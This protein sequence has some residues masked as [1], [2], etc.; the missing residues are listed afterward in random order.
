[1]KYLFHSHPSE[2]KFPSWDQHF[3]LCSRTRTFL[4]VQVFHSD[5]QILE[6]MAMWGPQSFSSANLFLRIWAPQ[7][8]FC[9]YPQVI[10]PVHSCHPYSTSAPRF[11]S[12]EHNS[13]VF[14]KH[15]QKQAL[16]LGRLALAQCAAALS[17]ALWEHGGVRTIALQLPN[18]KISSIAEHQNSIK[19]VR[20]LFVLMCCYD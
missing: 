13:Q 3:P 6:C 16:Y 19:R 20:T 12:T 17:L 14:S 18:V 9:L 11:S 7:S 4:G 8:P 5:M 10:F 15:K 2:K 1:M